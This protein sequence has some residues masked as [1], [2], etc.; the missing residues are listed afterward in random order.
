VPRAVFAALMFGAA[1]VGLDASIATI[2]L[3]PIQR[4]LDA[5]ASQLQFVL[6][7]YMVTGAALALP[8]GALGDRIGRKRLYLGGVLCFVAGSLGSALAPSI[9]TLI[10]ARAVQG[11]GA[12]AMSA[13]A[14]AMVTAAVPRER[15]AAVV[16]I[17]AAVSAVAMGVGP[18]VGGL[19]VDVVGWR[20]VFGI[21]APAALLLLVVAG[22]ELPDQTPATEGRVDWVGP[23]L[24]T[25]ALVLVA[26]G[27]GES[28]TAGFARPGVYLPLASGL[29]LLG[30]LAFQQRA[31]DTPML[32]WRRLGLRPLPAAIGL[33]VILGIAL[34]GALYQLAQLLQHVL[35]YSPGTTGIVLVAMTAAFIV[36]S[37]LA[38][39]AANRIG[40][41]PL[42]MAGLLL[43]AVAMFLLAQIQAGTGELVVAGELL[44]LGAGLGIAMP[45][46]Q[47][48]AMAAAGSES[49][50]AASGALNLAAQIAAI[51]GIVLIGG[52]SLARTADAWDQKASSP[53][54]QA[55]QAEVAAG[56]FADVRRAAGPRAAEAAEDAYL[57]GVSDAFLIGA[58]GLVV[59]AAY[60]ALALR[61]RRGPSPSPGGG[62]VV[63]KEGA[64]GTV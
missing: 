16:G 64:G 11:I 23:G 13:L 55:L 45:A 7:A 44:L 31:S 15:L 30:L 17:W 29:L 25:A 47:G 18:V 60:A 35:D 59:S 41:A 39:K 1:L 26:V 38:G 53:M 19:L 12:A 62:A 9:E 50:G 58:G 8:V 5:P 61:T 36:T 33:S 3:P 10:A 51:L 54:L 2:A 56:D 37:P 32:D 46:V 49:S 21:N 52:L 27:L 57:A 20:W 48:A 40:L 43:A 63:T 6:I 34:T 14:L 28:E 4:E 42:A 24:L 22:Y